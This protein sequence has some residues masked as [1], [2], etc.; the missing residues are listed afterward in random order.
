MR[1]WRSFMQRSRIRCRTGRYRRSR[2]CGRGCRSTHQVAA[3]V[4]LI[5][6]TLKLLG[7]SLHKKSLRA[8]EPGSTGRRRGPRGMARSTSAK[9][10][11]GGLIFIDETWT[12]T[13]MIRLYGWAE[14]GHRL[15][16][17]VPHGHWNTSNFIAGRRQDGLVALACSNVSR[18]MAS[19]SSPMSSRF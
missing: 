9:P 10:D 14:V 15:I 6:H 19:C 17:A 5:W 11:A 7:L 4:G 12:K 13:N 8:A 1:S 16:D 2:N 18:S 3:S